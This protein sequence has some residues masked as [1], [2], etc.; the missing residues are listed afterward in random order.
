MTLRA[1]LEAHSG[2]WLDPARSRQS[3]ARAR[4]Q[5]AMDSAMHWATALHARLKVAHT[6]YGIGVSL[7]AFDGV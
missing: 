2:R 5:A 6:R 1:I 3:I 7:I 4:L